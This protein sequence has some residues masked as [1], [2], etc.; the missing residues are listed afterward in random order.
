MS[1]LIDTPKHGDLVYDVGMH[2]GEDSEFYLRK[3]FRVV[4]FEA[5]PDLANL[6]RRRLRHF[7]EE[8]QLTIVEGAIVDPDTLEPGQQKVRFYRNDDVSVWGTVCAD[9]AERNERLGTRITLIEIDAI[10]FAGVMREYGVPHF[11]KIDVEGVDMVCVAA[12]EKFRERPDY[13][14]MESDKTSFVM[15]KDEIDVLTR[16]GYDAFQAIE[17]SAIPRTQSPP[18]PPREG[19]FV[20]HRFEAGSSGLFGSELEDSW[21]S[22]DELLRQYRAI[23]LGYYLL[24]DDGILNRWTF[25]GSRRL[26]AYARRFCSALTSA[27]VPG[28]YDTHARHCTAGVQGAQA[29][30]QPRHL[31]AEYSN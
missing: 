30:S 14:S 21:K 6:G 9:W 4:A 25:R 11:L 20:P 10:D 26:K 23:H 24:G 7:I 5:N 19:Q 22:K 29:V 1:T 12:L 16:L 8:G 3:G 28:W 27:P 13:L 31:P 15:V 17:Q 2:A 18:Y